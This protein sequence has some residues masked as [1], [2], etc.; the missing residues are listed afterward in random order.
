V[1]GTGTGMESL[2]GSPFDNEIDTDL[3][4]NGR[5]MLSMANKGPG[6][7]GSQFFITYS[8]Q[9]SFD[10]KYTLFGRV[11]GG[12]ETLDALEMEPV[13]GKQFKPINKLAINSIKIHAN[14]IA[15]DE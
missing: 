11:I 15:D 13:S 14:P 6:T 5:G 9:E 8:K 12:F 4:H 2:Y 10:G 7:N 1:T 3:T